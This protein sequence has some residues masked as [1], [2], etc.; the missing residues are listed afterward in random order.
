MRGRIPWAAAY[1]EH[2]GEHANEHAN[3]HG[4]EGVCDPK[5]GSSKAIGGR[6]ELRATTAV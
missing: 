1:G 3:E 4:E 5:I 2:A 6:G